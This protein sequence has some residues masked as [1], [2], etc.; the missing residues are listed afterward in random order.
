MASKIIFGTAGIP[1]SSRARDSVEGIKRIKELGLGAMELEFVRG[2]NMKKE[3]AKKVGTAARENGVVLSVHAPYYIN[4]N[5]DE[6]E[7]VEA[8]KKR[9]WNSLE[10][11]EAAGAEIV[12]FHPAYFGKR[13]KQEAMIAVENALAELLEKMKENGMKIRLAPETTGKHSAF[14]SLEETLELCKRLDGV[15]PMLDFSHLHARLNGGL[16]GKEDFARV[17]EKVPAKHLKELRMHA[18]GIN[19]SEKGERNHL[20]MG[21]SDFNYRAM[22]EA[23][24]GA[25]VSGVVI[26]ESPNLEE[27][28]L[29]MK[30]TWEKL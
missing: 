13:E 3:T 25:G 27:D 24:K 4:L 23:L 28:A 2:V 19:Y 1:H 9:I 30:S 16:K 8:S 21:E 15:Q 6:R 22:L 14:G 17:L 26:C 29:L 18:S 5:S 12:T 20:N 10:I 11:G 7:K